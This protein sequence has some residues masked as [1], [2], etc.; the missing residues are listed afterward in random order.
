[1]SSARKSVLDL[2][3]VAFVVGLRK[4]LIASRY[5]RRKFEREFDVESHGTNDN[6]E[7]MARR[8]ARRKPLRMV[9]IDRSVSR[10]CEAIHEASVNRFH[11]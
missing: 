9:E 3:G 2:F 5:A 8:N 10:V 7:F 1:L 4:H 11:E 6:R